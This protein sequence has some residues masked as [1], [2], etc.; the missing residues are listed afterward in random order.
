MVK[1]E[2]A[3]MEQIIEQRQDELNHAEVLMTD[4]NGIAKKINNKVH[5]QRDVLIEIN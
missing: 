4:I 5:E 1:G 2:L 3:Y